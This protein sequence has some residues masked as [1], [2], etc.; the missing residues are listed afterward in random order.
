MVRLEKLWY[1]TLVNTKLVG[2]NRIIE[3]PRK[4]RAF[5]PQSYGV[6]VAQMYFSGP[7]A[8]VMKNLLLPWLSRSWWKPLT[9]WL[10][11]RGYAYDDLMIFAEREVRR[12]IYF[13]GLARQR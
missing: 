2:R 11:T 13:E 4:W 12:C 5:N 3:R 10:H 7:M 8:S 9:E 1:E 6:A